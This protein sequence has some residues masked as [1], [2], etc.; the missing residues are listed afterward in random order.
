MYGELFYALSFEGRDFASEPAVV[1]RQEAR[2]WR[3]VPA[4]PLRDERIELELQFPQEFLRVAVGGGAP[5]LL[6]AGTLVE[7]AGPDATLASVW[8]RLTPPADV[9]PFA[10]LGA[11]RELGGPAALVAERPFPWRTMALWAV[12]IG[13]VLVVG[14]MAVRLARDMRSQS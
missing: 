10:S 13:G 2:Y 9:V 4:A 12:L 8:Q 14:A 7:D 5:Y 11:R 1:G 6:A 3:V